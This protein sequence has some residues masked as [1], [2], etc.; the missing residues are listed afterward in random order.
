MQDFL[1]N[2]NSNNLDCNLAIN[3]LNKL[4]IKQQ[5][6]LF[7]QKMKTLAH[8]NHLSDNLNLT[9]W[10]KNLSVFLQ[11]T[12]YKRIIGY[13]AILNEPQLINITN[14]IPPQAK[15]IDIYLGYNLYLIPCLAIDKNFNRLG[16]GGGFYDKLIKAVKQ[17]SNSCQIIACGWSWQIVN[18]LP[19]Q[20]HDQKIDGFICETDIKV[21]NL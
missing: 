1:T 20:L 12:P 14:F 8:K 2:K 9:N 10:Q 13:Q 17:N 4:N 7:R 21:A 11:K 6:D 16:R 15:Q 5:K 3:K 18:N 19:I